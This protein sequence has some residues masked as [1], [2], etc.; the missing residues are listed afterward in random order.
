M[1]LRSSSPRL[2]VVPPLPVKSEPPK[3]VISRWVWVLFI[4]SLL[5]FISTVFYLSWS[6]TGPGFFAGEKVLPAIDR[7]LPG[8]LQLP[9]NQSE[10]LLPLVAVLGLC[11][12]LRFIPPNNLTRLIIK[13]ILLG[14][15]VRYLVW[16]TIATLN[17]SHWASTTLSLFLYINE[18][19]CFISF[20]LFTV[21]TIWGSTEKRKAEADRYAQ[22]VLAGRYVPWV[23][24]LI[25]TYNESE[26]IVRRTAIGCQA[27]DYPHKRIYILDDTRRPSMRQLAEELG[28][29][30]ITRPDNAHAKAGN[31]NHALNHT[32]SELI[33]VFDADFVP[34]RGFLNRTIGFFQRP[35]IT[36]VQTKQDFYNPDYY[37]RNLGVAHLLPND[38]EAFYGYIQPCWDVANSVICC[39]TSYVVR[40]EH[41]EAIG[42]YYTRCCV[43]DLQ[44]S[45]LMRSRGLRLVFLNETLSMGESTRTY[46]DF[47][48][49]RLRWLQGNL[50]IHYCQN[51]IPFWRRATWVQKL[52]LIS[53]L[54]CTFSPVFRLGFLLTPLLSAYLGVLPY[55]AT[56]LEV[57]YYFVPFILLNFVTGGWTS[58][59]RTSTFWNEVY[60]TAFCFPGLKRIWIVLRN[61]FTKASRVTRKGVKAES[62]V[63]NFHLTL[64]LLILL[65]LTGLIIGIYLVGYFQGAW[66]VMPP[67]SEVT[68][69][70]LI[71]NGV[72]MSVAVLS[73]I[74]QPV[75]RASDRFPVQTICSLTI[76]NR[77][78]WGY[79]ENLSDTGAL[80]RLTQ[81]GAVSPCQTASLEFAEYGFAVQAEIRRVDLAGQR[82]AL[83]FSQ[84]T[85]E[86]NRHLVNL[87][88]G[89]LTWWKQTRKVGGLDALLALLGSL[90][91]FRPL[92][93]SYD[94]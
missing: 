37:A 73:A 77:V 1:G 46:A 88:Y 18:A 66:L 29:G 94:R 86:Q 50:Q 13:S 53:H 80:I 78:Y 12:L 9:L 33:A 79:S 11:A 16:R 92:L 64:P 43:E 21:C 6:S 84:V 67:G 62:K 28:C 48:D 54:L 10:I 24:V 87:L 36:L 35:Q 4:G 60:D 56:P 72:L 52:Y 44:T 30:Y 2:T 38:Q 40:R 26:A 69:F 14:L 70:W 15:A 25:P 61:P 41:L 20:F 89:D 31:L 59:Y 27:M 8:Y 39:G 93:N 51:E 45:F 22:D 32:S 19:V 75:R 71:Y 5:T 90:I 47:L 91:K 63:Y 76:G 42:G 74:D 55:I 83:E 85:I 17:F 68:C 49:Q 23:D 34:F 57:V 65:G 58:G 3:K 82:V 7:V 81:V